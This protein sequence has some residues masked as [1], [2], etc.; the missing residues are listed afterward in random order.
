MKHITV[1]LISFLIVTNLSAQDKEVISQE[2]GKYFETLKAKDVKASLEYIYPKIFEIAPKGKIEQSMN[3]TF[4]DPTLELNFKDLAIG[5]VS[6]VIVQDGVKYALI[7]YSYKMTIKSL[8]DLGKDFEKQLLGTYI[9]MYGKNNVE[10][11]KKTKTYSIA[12]TTSMYA[13]NSPKYSGWKFLEN[14]KGM[15]IILQKLIPESV[16]EQLN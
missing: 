10:Y 7:A 16:T 4:N 8:E 3:E 5:T 9:D 15:E 11:D 12:V 6:D 2:V 14:K 1:L 13:I